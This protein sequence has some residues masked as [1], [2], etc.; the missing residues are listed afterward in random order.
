MADY[1]FD[2]TQGDYI[3]CNADMDDLFGDND[4]SAFPPKV[5]DYQDMDMAKEPLITVDKARF[6][7]FKQYKNKYKLIWGMISK[8]RRAFEGGSEIKAI[9]PLLLGPDSYLYRIF[10]DHLRIPYPKFA[11]FM[12]TFLLVCQ[13]NTNLG[14]LWENELMV[15]T[16][17]M[18]QRTRWNLL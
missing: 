11:H 9:D 14:K 12:A 2:K 7:I 16:L 8:L 13:M 3:N 6:D 15:I 4:N 18:C 1:K 5:L 10:F 17:I